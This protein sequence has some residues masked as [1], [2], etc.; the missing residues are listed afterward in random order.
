VQRFLALLE[1][2]A[3]KVPM[4]LAG[5]DL[6]A[7]DQ[8]SPI[9]H[10]QALD[11]RCRVRPV[12]RAAAGAAQ[13]AAVA[14]FEFVPAARAHPPAVQDSHGPSV[15]ESAATPWTCQQRLIK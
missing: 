11:G 2:A 13:M 5:P 8:H 7:T 10:K 12:I 6:P 3:R 4:A 1:E 15:E 9:P 14:R